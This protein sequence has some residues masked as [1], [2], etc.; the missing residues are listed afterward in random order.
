MNLFLVARNFLYASPTALGNCDGSLSC[1]SLLPSVIGSI[2]DPSFC[3][4]RLSEG[5]HVLSQEILVATPALFLEGLVL[6]FFI[7]KLFVGG[8]RFSG[9]VWNKS[10]LAVTTVNITSLGKVSNNIRR[11]SGLLFFIHKF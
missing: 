9:T 7:W 6:W 3:G 2:G 4:I 1:P 8:Y 10:P 5:T 11:C